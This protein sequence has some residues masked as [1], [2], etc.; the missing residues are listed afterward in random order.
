MLPRAP[1]LMPQSGFFLMN[2]L[3]TQ[4]Q[5]PLGAE[6]GKASPSAVNVEQLLLNPRDAANL[7]C[8][9]CLEILESPR[10]VQRVFRIV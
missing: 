10:C 8:P 1:F 2:L 4:A 9:I 7:K 5:A 6:V 3:R